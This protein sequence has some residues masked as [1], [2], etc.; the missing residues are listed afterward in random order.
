[1]DIPVLG[2][3]RIDYLGL[4]FIVGGPCRIAG[5]RFAAG[6]YSDVTA[7]GTWRFRR[8]V[9]R[10]ASWMSAIFTIRPVDH[11]HRVIIQSLVAAERF[12]LFLRPPQ[13]WPFIRARPNTA[14]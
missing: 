8:T 1:M 2:G 10:G 5:R 14:P 6:L 13:E 3:C 4:K 9:V 11:S 7:P 12:L